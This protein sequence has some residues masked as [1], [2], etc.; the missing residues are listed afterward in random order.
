MNYYTA[1]KLTVRKLKS[2]EQFVELSNFLKEKEIIGYA[3]CDG[4][5]DPD[6]REAVFYPF[7]QVTWYK[8][9]ED[10]VMIAESFSKL[11]FELEG[12]GEDIGDFW[13][14]YYHDMDIEYCRGEVVY[15]QPKKVAWQE[16]V[17]I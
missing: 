12:V 1:Y 2:K 13:K 3:L 6:H 7:E 4:S 14:E 17:V 5:Y 8:H 10:M 16:L 11:Y 15:E 9:A